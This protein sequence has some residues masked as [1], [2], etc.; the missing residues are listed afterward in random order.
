[1]CP[2]ANEDQSVHILGVCTGWGGWG[3]CVFL[4]TGIYEHRFGGSISYSD[5]TT[6]HDVASQWDL[7]SLTPHP[8]ATL[9]FSPVLNPALMTVPFSDTEYRFLRVF[10]ATCAP[11]PEKR[12]SGG[13]GH[14]LLSVLL[15]LVT[16]S[17]CCGE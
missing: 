2:D 17:S 10:G 5:L 9:R 12:E 3:A 14:R 7:R 13:C 8:A 6:L 16:R 1:M 11:V 4:L 15:L